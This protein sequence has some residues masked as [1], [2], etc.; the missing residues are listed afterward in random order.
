MSIQKRIQKRTSRRSFRVRNKLRTINRTGRY[1]V[2]VFRSNAEL[3]LQVIDDKQ[4]H[5]LVGMSTASLTGVTG[6]KTEKARQLGLCVGQKA[7]EQNVR[8]VLFDRGSFMYHGRVKAAAEG[9]RESG[10]QF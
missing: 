3:Y 7:V 6:D 5:T 9:L 10:L 2:S 1:R 4:G 8:E